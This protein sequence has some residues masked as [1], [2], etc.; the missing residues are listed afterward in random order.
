MRGIRDAADFL[1]N[2]YR[3][4]YD[5]VHLRGLRIL[6][7]AD[8]PAGHVSNGTKKLQEIVINGCDKVWNADGSGIANLPG[9]P[10]L[11]TTD[12]NPFTTTPGA[13]L[14]NEE[15]TLL[16]RDVVSPCVRPLLEKSENKPYMINFTVPGQA[17]EAVGGPTE[18][19]LTAGAR[20]FGSSLVKYSI[21]A[22]GR[23]VF[24]RADAKPFPP[25]HAE[26]LIAFIKPKVEP[27]LVAAISGLAENIQVPDRE[28]VLDYICRANFEPYY[29]QFAAS[30]IESGDDSWVGLPSPYD[31]KK[32]DM[33]SKVTEVWADQKAR[34]F[35]QHSEKLARQERGEFSRADMIEGMQSLGVSPEAM[36]SIIGQSE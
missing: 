6:G 10:W 12:H 34:G 33:S 2:T 9:I 7:T 24:V 28:T 17:G 14:R 35:E 20:G 3:D 5:Q 11:A 4:G 13:A 18:Q 1:G 26:A 23:A 25:Q 8:A 30:K 22:N 36:A 19:Q 21:D 27:K 29:A 16:F 31:I 32:G 15:V